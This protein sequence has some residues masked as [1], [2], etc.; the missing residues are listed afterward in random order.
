MPGSFFFF[1][2]GN[3]A[4][5][6][7]EELYMGVFQMFHWSFCPEKFKFKGKEKL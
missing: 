2:T 7:E 6:L 3:W 4:E 5:A 1:Q